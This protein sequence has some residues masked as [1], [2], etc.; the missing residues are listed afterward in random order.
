MQQVLGYCNFL[1]A[2]VELIL[3]ASKSSSILSNAL[4]LIF[5]ARDLQFCI[6]RNVKSHQLYH[7]Y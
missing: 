1:F 6:F 2:V 3:P 4:S 5:A 7:V